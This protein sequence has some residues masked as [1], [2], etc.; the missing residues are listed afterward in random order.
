MIQRNFL[1]HKCFIIY[2]F[3]LILR[4]FIYQKRKVVFKLFIYTVIYH[5][6]YDIPV[7]Y[8]HLLTEFNGRV[9]RTV[10]VST[11]ASKGALVRGVSTADNGKPTLTAFA[12]VTDVNNV[13]LTC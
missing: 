1:A 13:L 4:H 8:T 3:C 9:T 12:L 7:S 6:Y 11:G 2:I 10:I 5:D